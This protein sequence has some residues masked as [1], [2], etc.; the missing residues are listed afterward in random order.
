MGALRA[1]R[2]PLQALGL[3]PEH[4]SP[5]HA[6]LVLEL[7]SPPRDEMGDAEADARVAKLLGRQGLAGSWLE[8]TTTGYAGPRGHDLPEL[9]LLPRLKKVRREA[10][11]SVRVSPLVTLPRRLGHYDHE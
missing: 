11:I 2:D 4:F 5:Q 7:V 6:A 10:G 9:E 1:N 3:P 8:A